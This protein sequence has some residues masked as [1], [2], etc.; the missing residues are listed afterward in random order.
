MTAGVPP[1]IHQP[2]SRRWLAQYLGTR[3]ETISRALH[4]LEVKGAIRI[5]SADWFFVTDT[6]KLAAIA[7]QDLAIDAT[8]G[9]SKAN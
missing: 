1:A 6:S 4:Q 9:H 5:E 7:G 3:P 8:S 2:L